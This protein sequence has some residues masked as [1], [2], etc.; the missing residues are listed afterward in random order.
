MGVDYLYCGECE[1]CYHED[2]FNKC[3]HCCEHFEHKSGHGYCCEG[4]DKKYKYLVKGEVLYF[5][6]KECKKIYLNR[7]KEEKKK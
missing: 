5:C 1:E 6:D 2:C 3:I 4:C 7:E